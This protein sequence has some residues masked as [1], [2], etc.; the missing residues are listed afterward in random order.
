MRILSMS[1]F[2]PE[3]ICDIERFVSYPGDHNISHFCGY[4]SD[5]ISQVIKEKEI[6]GA[7]FPRSCDSTRS[8]ST[9][10]QELGKFSFQ[11]EIPCSDVAGSDV[12]FANQLI[13]YKKKVETHFGNKI[14]E[15][16]IYER[17]DLINK[18]NEKLKRLYDNIDTLSFADYLNTIHDKLKKPLNE[19]TIDSNGIKEISKGEKIYIVGS[20]LS[21]I[22]IAYMMEDMGLNIVGDSLPE[23]GRLVNQE[24]K[25]QKDLYKSIAKSVLDQKLSPTQNGFRRSLANDLEEIRKKEAKG[26]IFIT[27]KYC[28][29]YDYYYSVAK[30]T[31]EENG[32]KTTHMT[33]NG[34]NDSQKKALLTLEAFADTL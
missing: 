18:R 6:D 21:N 28:E 27:Q 2:I 11:F 23:S 4:V 7:V 9:Y 30:K 29:A 24:I 1:G 32:I 10:L 12:F 31:F 17:I 8:I 19:Q 14:S 16:N 26:V 33:V 20:F 25:I 34:T 13:E 15:A 3:H 22:K 5:F